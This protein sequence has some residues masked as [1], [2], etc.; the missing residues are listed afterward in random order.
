MDKLPVYIVSFK[1]MSYTSHVPAN[2]KGQPPVHHEYNVVVDA[3]TGEP[4]M[5][6]SNR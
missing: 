3:T 2:F 6:F 5:G 4:L 1:G